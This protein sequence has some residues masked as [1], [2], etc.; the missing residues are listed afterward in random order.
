MDVPRWLAPPTFEKKV[1]PVALVVAERDSEHECSDVDPECHQGQP[2]DQTAESHPSCGERHQ[3][4]SPDPIGEMPS[5]QIGHQPA[6]AER[7]GRHPQLERRHRQLTAELGEER[8]TEECDRGEGED[9]R[10]NR[11]RTLAARQWP[12]EDGGN[13]AWMGRECYKRLRKPPGGR[14]DRHPCTPKTRPDFDSSA[15]PTSTGIGDGM[16]VMP[17][18]DTLYV[19]HFGPSGKGTSIL[20]ISDRTA[21]RVVRQWDA[22]PGRTPTRCRWPTVFW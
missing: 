22:P 16:Q 10:R 13:L 11:G 8:D 18:G 3:A 9:C 5:G 1:I 20:D 19:A 21:P 12:G 6:D 2:E 7:G 17:H 15:T 4:A 14:R